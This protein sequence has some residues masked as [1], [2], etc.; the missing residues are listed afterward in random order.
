MPWISLS[1]L[2][3]IAFALFIPLLPDNH[4]VVKWYGLGVT[5]TTFLITVVAYITGYDPSVSGLQMSERVPW[6]PAL[7]LTWSVGVDGLS[8]PLVLLTSF[9]TS[10]AGSLAAWTSD[11]QTKTVLFSPPSDGRR[12]DCSFR[13]TRLDSI[14][15]VMGT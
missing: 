3:P 14:L 12:T 6:V 8:M 13:R 5:L 2:F 1:I 10:L 11:I 7:G 15:P 9:I 4:K